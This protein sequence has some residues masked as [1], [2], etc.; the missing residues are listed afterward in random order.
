MKKEDE[1]R[2]WLINDREL[3]PKP[4]ADVLSRCRRA[5][6]MVDS[7][8]DSRARSDGEF[9]RL[10]AEVS[11]AVLEDGGNVYTTASLRH[12]LRLYSEFLV[13]PR[14]NRTKFRRWT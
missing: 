2:S 8:I 12:A 10:M 7:S 13:G 4:A 9:V 5:E 1:F 3:G 6:R 11:D 14:A